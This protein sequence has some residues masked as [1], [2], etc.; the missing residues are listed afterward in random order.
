MTDKKQI[1]YAEDD[2]RYSVP[3]V[4]DRYEPTKESHVEIFRMI[5]KRRRYRPSDF[6]KQTFIPDLD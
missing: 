4:T 3:N 6:K 2:T 5:N 1:D